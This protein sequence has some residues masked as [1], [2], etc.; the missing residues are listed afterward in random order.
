M[1]SNLLEHTICLC[2]PQPV[3]GCPGRVGPSKR[4]TACR[5]C[6][7]HL[8]ALHWAPDF[9]KDHQDQQLKNALCVALSH[10]TESGFRNGRWRWGNA[11]SGS[12]SE[13]PVH[14]Q[15]SIDTPKLA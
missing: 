11:V 3:P 12:H 2:F 13:L 7:D 1:V 15:I 8:S 4:V 10:D 5:K 9:S 6:V 14:R